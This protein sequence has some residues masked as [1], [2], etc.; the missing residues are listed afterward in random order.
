V[1]QGLALAPVGAG[2]SGRVVD[3]EVRP[4][5]AAGATYDHE[6]RVVVGS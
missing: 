2:V 3:V 5:D 1:E 4:Y 6:F